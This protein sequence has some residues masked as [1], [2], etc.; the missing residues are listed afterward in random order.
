[1]QLQLNFTKGT[2]IG[3]VD[4]EVLRA[5]MRGK[6]LRI[7]SVV[8]IGG[9]RR[10]TIFLDSCGSMRGKWSAALT[11]VMD[12]TRSVPN[13][14]SLALVAESKIIHQKIEFGPNSRREIAVL[15]DGLAKDTG[16]PK[17]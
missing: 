8:P 9:P 2:P 3:Q 11:A 15:V 6:P 1:V 10:T 13:D 14:V 7:E 17:G 5:E 4:P 16:F 12:L